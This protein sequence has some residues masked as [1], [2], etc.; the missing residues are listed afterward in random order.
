[1]T[2]QDGNTYPTVIIGAQEWMA[3][4]LRTITYA[5]GDT[6]L[7]VTEDSAW[8]MMQSGAWC[9]YVN[10]G[11]NDYSN[12]KLYNW[13]AASNPNICPQGWHLPT[14]AEWQQLESALGMPFEHLELLGGLRGVEQNVGRKLKSATSWGLYDG[15]TNESGFSGIPAGFRALD[16][17]F[18][19]LGSS[20]SFWSASE[21]DMN[22]AWSR[23]LTSSGVGVTRVGPNKRSGFCLRCVRD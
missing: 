2:D 22:L 5:N 1:M 7:N 15:G 13:F 4:N 8:G 20:G 10:N 14:D 11:T 16:G 21:T 19:G 12:G 3:Q 17:F 18:N 23:R 6:I 9:H